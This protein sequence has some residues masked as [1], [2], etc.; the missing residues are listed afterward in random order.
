M[1]TNGGYKM[2]TVSC[3]ECEVEMAIPY[4]KIQN[5][6]IIGNELQ[7]IFRGK[8]KFP[9]GHESNR[10]YRYSERHKNGPLGNGPDGNIVTR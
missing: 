2:V 3:P 6:L 7:F 10:A 4:D 1:R 5:H 8:I 9:C